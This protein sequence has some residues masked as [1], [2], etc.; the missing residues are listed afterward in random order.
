MSLVYKKMNLL[1][2]PKGSVLVHACNAKGVW[3]SGIA[4]EMKKRFPE[5]YKD[6][7]HFCNMIWYPVGR[8]YMS[9]ENDKCIVSL[10]TSEGYGD[11][12]DSPNEILVN[13][14]VALHDLAAHHFA[15]NNTMTVYSN[16]FNS[17][18]F[19]VPWEETEK[20]I[21]V[22]VDKYNLDWVVCEI[23]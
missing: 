16:K 23:D 2:A 8:Y 1:D 15:Y 21:K 22:F 9:D 20:I 18:L 6:Y 11:S 7:K 5:A 19:K 3:G 10:I 4:K 13:T 14:S 17:G 12:V